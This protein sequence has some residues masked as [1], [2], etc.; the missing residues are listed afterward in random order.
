MIRRLQMVPMYMDC[1]LTE[2]DGT[3]N[4]IRHTDFDLQLF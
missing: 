3:V 4:G 2:L 1:L